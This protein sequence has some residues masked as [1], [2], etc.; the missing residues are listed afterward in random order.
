MTLS[1]PTNCKKYHVLS[2]VIYVSIYD[3]ILRPSC[4]LPTKRFSFFSEV[5]FFQTLLKDVHQHCSL[6]FQI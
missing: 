5:F 4:A 6:L 3:A 2:V 1:L